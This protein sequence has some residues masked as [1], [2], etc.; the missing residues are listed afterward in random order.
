M[1]NTQNNL[2]DA[3][4]DLLLAR[5]ETLAFE[6]QRQLVSLASSYN[7]T[8]DNITT[9]QSEVENLNKL[10][11]GQNKYLKTLTVGTLEHDNAQAGLERV[12]A[13]LIYKQQELSNAQISYNGLISEASK[14]VAMIS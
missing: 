11:D 5:K 3:E 14:L 8:K 9:L 12:Y 13:S 6:I 10:F 2:S 4:R 1:V 7:E